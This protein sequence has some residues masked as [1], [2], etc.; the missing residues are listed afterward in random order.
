[1]AVTKTHPIKSTLKAA[2]DYIL[3]PEKTD[4]KLLASSFGCGLETADIEFAWTR[5]AAGD[6]GTHL[7]RH[8]IQSFAVGETTPEEAHKI[9][10]ELAQAVLGGKYE[11]VLTTHV[12]K[13]HLH[14]HLIFNAVSFVDY[15]KYHS[16]KQSYHFIRRT[17]DRIC[18]EHGLSV[19]VPGQ[20]KGKSYAEYTAEKQ[21]TSYKAKLKTAIDTLIPQVKDFDEL[22]RRLQEMGYEIKQGKYISFRAAGQERFTRTK[23]LGA[24]YTEEAHKIGME[25]AGAVL[26][27][28]YEFVLTTHVD[29]DHL[30]NHLIF[31]SVSFVDYK[32]Y[33][34][35]KQSYYHIRRT[36]DR[37]CKE[38][39]LSVVVPGQDRGK[40]YAEYTAEKQGTSYK[41]KLKTAI[42]NLIPRVKDFDELLRRLQEMG[43]EIKQGKYIS[44]RAAGQERFTRTKTLGAAYTEEAIKER[45][46]GVYVAKT[47][48]LREDKKIRLVVDLENSI[49]AQQ[50]AGYERWAKIHNLKQ[51]AKSMNF[52]TENK[53][54]YYSELESKIADIMTAH[55]AAAKAVKEVEQ[56]MSDLSLLIK[57]TTTYRQLKPIYDEYRKSP[58]K[59]KYLR[60][61][62][63]E[64]I[65]FE[66]AA[67]ALKEMQIK[68]LPDLAALRKEYRSLND[69]KTKLYEDYRQAKK[70]MQ[71]YGVVKKNVDSILY[72][73]QSRAREQER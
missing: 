39:G 71:E 25:L 61:H 52:L 3:N 32:K 55:D 8:L 72:P 9:G 33:H 12:D 10:M 24:A 47:K 35:N 15:K 70:Q 54:E 16:N 2:I 5:E 67:R 31:N 42:D 46:K 23:T 17:S 68:K 59:E 29:K 4:G 49:K 28:K 65:L 18:K 34:S 58:D 45:I 73:S 30:H 53:I 6:R 19:V 38:H 64:I 66:A 50:S 7:G 21:G 48:T 27:G 37:I 57:H 1:M 11:F 56:R 14:N 36:S 13:D 62:E 44:F 69:R 40:S 51:A 20:D 22:L 63:S 41:A 26:G 43:Y 60:G